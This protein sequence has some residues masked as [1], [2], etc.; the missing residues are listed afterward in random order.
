MFNFF[1]KSD[2]QIQQD[3]T[4]EIKNDPSIKS[5]QVSNSTHDGIVTLRGSVPH[6]FEKSRAVEAAQRVGGVRAVA[7]EIEVNIMGSY[8]RTD[9]QIAEA[10]LNALR[11][12]YTVPSKVDVV[13]E[14]G[15]I[16]LKGEAEW[17]YE[18]RAA[19]RAV[20]DLMGVTGVTN[21]IY[22]K[23]KSIHKAA[24]IKLRIEEALKRSAEIEGRKISV[25]VDGN[26][27][28]LSGNVHSFG[29]VED[30]KHAAWMSPGIMSVVN[31]I[32]ISQ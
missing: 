27:V 16:T 8:I 7:D 28:T 10:A 24:D 26:Q 4:N 17:D 30:A 18:R 6:Y 31:H 3:V 20:R 2:S 22:L 19:Q 11:W 21:L 12:S 14:K 9:E 23:S 1:H 13:V 32:Q 5:T 29:E 15:W 25:T